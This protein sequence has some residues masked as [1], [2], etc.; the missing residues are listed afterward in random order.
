MNTVGRPRDPLLDSRVFAG[1]CDLY[2]RKGW[3][4]F[5]VETLSKESGVGK[6]SIYLRWPDKAALL[7]DALA[8]RILLPEDI[9]TGTVR[10]DLRELALDNLRMY[11]GPAGD[12]ALRLISES[13]I[14]PE[15]EPGWRLIREAHVLAVRSIVRRGIERHDLPRNT[16]V[17]LVLDALFGGLLMHVQTTPATH[18]DELPSQMTAYA[19]HFVDFILSAAT[20]T[21]D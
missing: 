8:A 2:G 20:A 18:I 15:I 3:A 19:D 11:L 14:V 10:G 6:A 9:D 7:L 5:S 21:S 16:P 4:G 17:T 12:A 1:A 13:R